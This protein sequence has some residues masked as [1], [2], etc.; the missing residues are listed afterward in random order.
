MYNF[1]VKGWGFHLDVTFTMG[2]YST[3]DQRFIVYFNLIS[4]L[5]VDGLLQSTSVSPPPPLP[6]QS[7]TVTT[8][9]QYYRI[10]F[11]PYRNTRKSNLYQ[12]Y[13]PQ[14]HNLILFRWS[15]DKMNM[16]FDNELC[17]EV[18]YFNLVKFC[19]EI[20]HIIQVLFHFFCLLYMYVTSY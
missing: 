8:R 17:I 10:S 19:E 18:L 16:Q 9:T 2:I 12:N 14:L 1:H 6:P 13:P 11:H 7:L 15:K 20:Y 5:T 3:L 4:V